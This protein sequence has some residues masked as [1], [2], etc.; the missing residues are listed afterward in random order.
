M[1]EIAQYSLSHFPLLVTVG[2]P[3]TIPNHVHDC[4]GS[5][6]IATMNQKY[7]SIAS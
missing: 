2:V 3:D 1:N 7:L 6:I 4:Q 5:L